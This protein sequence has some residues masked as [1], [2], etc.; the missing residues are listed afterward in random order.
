VEHS[1]R[2]TTGRCPRELTYSPV[3][4]TLHLQLAE[5]AA[6]LLG[7]PADYVQCALLPVAYTLGTDFRPANRPAPETI[8]HWD[9]W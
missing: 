9:R 5:R 7:I 4:R 2:R 1:E 6:E 3:A 8:V